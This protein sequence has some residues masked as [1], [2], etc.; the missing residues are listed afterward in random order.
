MKKSIS[1]FLT[2]SIISFFSYSQDISGVWHGILEANGTK[3]RVSFNIVKIEKGY[4]ST[5]DNPDQNIMGYKVAT[6]TFQDNALVLE[7]PEVGIHYKGTLNTENVI[8][9][10][11]SQAEYIIPL[12]LAKKVIQKTK[13]FM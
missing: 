8:E 4:D 9:G 2:C 3:L 13:T 6:T 12:N 5:L 1:L 7:I 10:T 11:Y